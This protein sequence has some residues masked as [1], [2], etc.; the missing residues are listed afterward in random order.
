MAHPRHTHVP[1]GIYFVSA[2]GEDG[3]AVFADERDRVALGELVGDVIARCGARLYAFKWLEDELLLLLQVYG[4]SLSGVMQRITSVHARRVN[5]K[6]G[7][8]GTL[9][10]HPHRAVLL[11]DSESA[12]EALAT[13]HR[14]P[15][16][17]WCSH[18][19]YLGLEENPWLTKQ[20]TLNLLSTAPDDQVRAY[21]SLIEQEPPWKRVDLGRPG[22]SSRF[23]ERR[24]Y[25]EFVGWL[26]SRCRERAK[27]ASLD[28]LIKAVARWFRVDPAAIES[29]ATSPLLSLA[30]ALITWTAMQNEIASLAELAQ[31]FGRSRSTLYQTRESYRVL[32][33]QL[34]NIRLAEILRGPD[35]PV[36]EV[37]QLPGAA[38][39]KIDWDGN[40]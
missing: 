35:V 23:N 37:L 40:G 10:Q 3:E 34:F 38:R 29:S 17:P 33:P 32:A 5:E 15:A 6:L 12:L 39:Q 11:Q 4:V 25:D 13:I 30:R 28:Q 20:L 31:R 27:P 2:I 19:A 36:P 14:P 9:F 8:K 24:P 18:L 22:R 1:G 21:K 7:Q 26:K 16:S